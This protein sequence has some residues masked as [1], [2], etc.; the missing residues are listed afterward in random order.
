MRS[1]ANIYS[2]ITNNHEC[3]YLQKLT[4]IIY[5]NTLITT[6][7]SINPKR[8]RNYKFWESFKHFM[9]NFTNIYSMITN[10]HKGLVF[11]KTN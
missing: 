7:K 9:R 5:Y 1:F 2:I 3:Q 11:T 6:L 8:K 4:K 10:N